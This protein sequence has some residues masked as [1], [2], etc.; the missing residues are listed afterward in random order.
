MSAAVSSLL[1]SLD[2]LPSSSPLSSP[3]HAR[4]S[5]QHVASLGCAT[6]LPTVERDASAS[7][8]VPLRISLG[9]LK[10]PT[11]TSQAQ[12]GLQWDLGMV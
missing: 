9:D 3:S 8:S 12:I 6:Q 11:R 1:P 7:P 4:Q 10:I 5:P 2:V